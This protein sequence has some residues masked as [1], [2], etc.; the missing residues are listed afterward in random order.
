MNA[1]KKLRLAGAC[2]AIAFTIVSC[3]SSLKNSTESYSATDALDSQVNDE[4]YNTESYNL[5]V[6]NDFKK[7][8]DNPF[9]TFSIDVDGASYSNTRRFINQNQLPPAD[10]VRIEEFINYFE[11]DYPQPNDGKPFTVITGNATCPWNTEHQLVQIALQGKKIPFNV[12]P[13]CNL[14]FLI[15]VSGSMDDDNKLPLVKKSLKALTRQLRPQD[16]IAMV[17]Y[18]GAA[19]VVLDATSGNER[20]TIYDAIDNLKA[21]GSTAGGAG[22]TLAYNIAK[23]NCSSHSNNRI[24]M[25]TDGDFNTG[26]SSDAAM[27]RLLEA[28]RDNGIYITTLGFGMG[29]YKDSKMEAIADCGNGNYFYID[30]YDEAE[31]VL[32]TQLD[33]TLFTIAKDVKLQVEFN[34]KVVQ[35]YRLVGYE[36]RILNKEDFKND[37]KDAGD[38]GAGHT[39]TAFY[40]VALT[41]ASNSLTAD[42]QSKYTETKVKADAADNEL[43]TVHL[44]YKLPDENVSS[45]FNTVLKNE[46]M[47]FENASADFR[48]AAAVAQYAMLLRNSKYKGTATLEQV[49]AAA[50]NAKGNDENS[51]RKSFVKMAEAT[52]GLIKE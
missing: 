35:S 11:Y 18:A 50:E 24:I 17:V 30:S 29:N 25:C 36:N 9:S 51:Y 22:L 23:Q 13:P 6:E 16:K 8:I 32:V 26:E 28:N 10:A 49:I 20:E 19:G 47:A 39:V 27:T 21:G 40:E 41:E 33:G 12:L 46:P 1:T 4:V 34:P 7:T 52:K 31:K 37:K 3:E 48:F 45:E 38:M 14:V 2:I 5:I 43:M 42:V 44:R 15:D